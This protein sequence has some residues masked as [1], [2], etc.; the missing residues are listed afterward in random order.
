MSW[1]FGLHIKDEFRPASFIA[2]CWALDHT[3]VFALP[4]VVLRNLRNLRN[5]NFHE[6]A[7]IILDL[8][9]SISY[10]WERR[11]ETYSLRYSLKSPMSIRTESGSPPGSQLDSLTE[12]LLSQANNNTCRGDSSLPNENDLDIENDA[13]IL[14][15]NIHRILT[16]T[17]CVFTGRSIWGQSVLAVFIFLLRPG[18]P[19]SV[20]YVMAVMGVCQ[21][22]ASFSA[23]FLANHCRRET[24]LKLASTIGLSAVAVTSLAVLRTDYLL[25][26]G[27]LSLWGIMWGIL[28]NSLASL[29]SDS[30]PKNK[31]VL[32][33][34]RGS[35]LMQLGNFSG[36]LIALLIFYYL[37]NKWSIRDCSIVMAA[38]LVLCVPAILILCCL[39]DD[40]D[41]DQT[42]IDLPIMISFQDSMEEKCEP[43]VSDTELACHTLDIENQ[44][45]NFLTDSQEEREDK[46]FQV[47]CYEGYLAKP[48]LITLA[49]MLSGIASGMSIRYFPIFLVDQLQLSPVQVHILCMVTVLGQSILAKAARGLAKPYGLCRVSALFQWIFVSLLVS[50]VVCYVRG[51]PVWL[52]C[53]LYVA[54]SSL[55]NSTGSLSKEALLDSVPKEDLAKWNS[56]ATLEMFLWSGSAAIGGVLVG[57]RGIVFNFYMTAGLQLLATLP[58]LCLFSRD[59]AAGVGST[60][61]GSNGF[62]DSDDENNLSSI[63]RVS[64]EC[65]EGETVYQPS[66]DRLESSSQSEFFDCLSC[67]SGSPG[68]VGGSERCL[69]QYIDGQCV[70]EDGT[71]AFAQQGD[72]ENVLPPHYLAACGGRRKKAMDMWKSSRKWRQE[73]EVWR[74]HQ[75]PNRWFPKIKKAYPHFVHGYTKDGYPVIYE[76]PGRMFLKKLFREGCEVSN[77]TTWYIFFMEYLSNC[78]CTRPEIRSRRGLDTTNSL[79]NSSSWGFVVVMDMEGVGPSI[80]SSD[81]VSYLTQAGVIQATH[82]PLSMKRTFMVNAGPVIAGLWSGLRVALPKSAQVDI[83]SAKKYHSSLR[84]CIVSLS[85]AFAFWN[86]FHW[87]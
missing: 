83:L 27:A 43:L 49:D 5:S 25:L 70:Y 20:G 37:G 32:Y 6:E 22:F 35:S 84:E 85:A 72:C 75:K 48:I 61:R 69:P 33:F 8:H 21:V 47:C 31:R 38:G 29:F 87:T 53:L 41:N 50:M 18:S 16:F 40:G 66:R 36:P 76:R 86:Q 57:Y 74:I 73:N 28:D 46:S 67:H 51:L 12:P 56:M 34:K 19:E 65:D 54:H 24:M 45:E 80:L 13:D 82:Y 14:S 71:P 58:L 52:I 26:V 2:E 4:T 60:E 3:F 77:M 44:E 42:D 17:W 39:R 1:P 79:L 15:T 9:Q 23:E 63:A 68:N 7:I 59:N 78:I 11:E 10:C 30:I 81:V 55:M 62:L 64:S